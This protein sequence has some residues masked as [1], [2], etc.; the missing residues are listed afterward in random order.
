MAGGRFG[1]GALRAVRAPRWRSRCQATLEFALV[2]PLFLLC[3]LATLDAA[4]WAVQTSAAVSSAE[5]AARLAAAAGGSARSEATAPTRQI[6]DLV[7]PRLRHALFGTS[8]TAWCDPN[9]TTP[10]STIGTA[11]DGGFAACPGRPA[12]VHDRFGPRTV[13]ICVQERSPDCVTF[14]CPAACPSP[15][16]AGAEGPNVTVRVTGYM[17]SLVPP[18]LG[19]G[20]KA[21]EIP[22]DIHVRTHAF[23][24]NP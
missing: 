6:V 18:A 15:G 7:A 8:V 20:W 10:C 22:I 23:R 16:C 5:E 13:A 2:S 11:G 12:D 21:G 14:A 1:G 4:L 24:F 19:L 3:L 9:P 17:T